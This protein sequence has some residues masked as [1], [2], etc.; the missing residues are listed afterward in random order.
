MNRSSNLALVFALA[1]GSLGSVACAAPAESPDMPSHETAG[2][3]VAGDEV[4]D[5]LSGESGDKPAQNPVTGF[6]GKTLAGSAVPVVAVL[7]LDGEKTTESYDVLAFDLGLDG[8]ADLAATAGAQSPKPSIRPM[9]LVVK[10]QANAGA[11]RKALFVGTTFPK[12]VLSQPG[13]SGKLTE[14]AILETAAVGALGANAADGGVVESYVVYAGAITLKHEDATVTFDQIK[15][16]TSCKEPCPCVLTGGNDGALGRYVQAPMSIPI[17]TKATRIDFASVNIRNEIVGSPTGAQSAKATLDG[18]EIGRALDKSGV[19]AAYYLA[20]GSSIPTLGIGVGAAPA[21]TK[22]RESTSWNACHASVKHVSF[23]AGGAETRMD[24]SFN[25]AG[26]IRTDRQFD[27]KTTE[28]TYGWS[29]VNNRAAAT[30]AD[31]TL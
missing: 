10:P 15:N 31:V 17:E 2:R 13:A 9:S 25:A 24:I 11:L 26:L 1:L 16:K 3:D 8:G 21:G 5:V 30:C 22:A 18:I 4:A 12:M 19:C 6:V 23:S 14:L 29:F 28:S 20:R 27:P 7:T